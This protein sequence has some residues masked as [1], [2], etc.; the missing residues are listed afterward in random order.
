MDLK[1]AGNQLSPLLE[2]ALNYAKNG[3]PVFPVKERDKVPLTVRGFKDATKDEATI[4][5]W[6]SRWP[7]ANIGL[8]TG[9]SAGVA[10]VDIDPRHG[11]DESIDFL[12]GANG[13]IPP[14]KVCMTGG[15]GRHLYF[16]FVPGFKNTAGRLGKG[17][18]TRGDGGYVILPPSV[19][20]S[21]TEYFWEDESEKVSTLPDWLQP[22][23]KPA[24]LAAGNLGFNAGPTKA[25]G[26]PVEEGGRNVAA[27]SLA[28]QYLRAGDSIDSV[29]LQVKAW[30][31]ANPSPLPTAEVERTVVSVARTH[32]QNNP[33]AEIRIADYSLPDAAPADR[34]LL[35]KF[36]AEL[37][38][39]PGVVGEICRYI[40][41]TAIM[42]QPILALGNALALFGAVIGRKVRTPTDL[43]SNLYVLGVGDSGCGKDHSRKAVKRICEAAGLTSE[44]LGGEEVSSDSAVL[45]A[46]HAHPSILFQ[47]D[48]IGHFISQANSRYAASHQKNIAPT[49][50]KLFSS[51]S[52]T[53]L[54]KEYA[55]GRERMDIVQP[56][57]SLYGTTVADRLYGGLT[58]GEV[59][60]GFLGRMIVF[61]SEDPDPTPQKV[62]SN[63]VPESI[64]SQVQAWW[65]RQD[66][67][68]AEGNIAAVTRHTPITV[69]IEPEADAE[70]GRFA[71]EC[72]AARMSIKGTGLDVIWSRAVEHA[73][74]VAL[75]VAC[76]C[77]YQTPI[78]SGQVA[79]YSTNLI[80]FN[81]Q[82]LI[83][84]VGDN[85]AGSEY[86]R[87]VLY[88]L[89]KIKRAGPGGISRRD[90]TQS[91]RK[92]RTQL[93]NECL[94]QLIDSSAI[95]KTERK[96]AGGF[97]ATIYVSAKAG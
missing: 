20:S 25:S 86:E 32:L 45:A 54:G 42:P 72:R 79:A 70:F 4:R 47:L 95:F 21:G 26:A 55:G 34:T 12:A 77:D 46:V 40:N 63:D 23:L 16:D 6:W 41:A 68:R 5:A 11:G 88:V 7:D 83:H 24:Q 29:L 43:R 36:P 66:L 91:T 75:V 90:L 67:P 69:E 35:Q 9:E 28:G 17:I 1:L 27:A 53:Y 92:L 2:A 51:A 33:G 18:D 8:P 62:K 96:G 57:V 81:V 38:D 82:S 76:G 19:H 84:E 13:G 10:V 85:L 74:K 3:W 48:E 30:N 71:V 60:D 58:P 52:T 59:S 89:R 22:G 78:I 49:F 94:T 61:K 15:G 31:A 14:T 93:R 50:T 44:I 87:D 56:N 37:L 73:L 80:G 97:P 65:S 39:P 64:V